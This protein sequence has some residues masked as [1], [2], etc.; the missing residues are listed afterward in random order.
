VADELLEGDG[1]SAL[2]ELVS[3]QQQQRTNNSG[4]GDGDSGTST[5]TTS[6]S[7]YNDDASEFGGGDIEDGASGDAGDAAGT[8]GGAS[9]PAR[10]FQLKLLQPADIRASVALRA[11]E[12]GFSG[13][14]TSSMVRALLAAGGWGAAASEYFYQVGGWCRYRVIA[15]CREVGRARRRERATSPTQHA[16][17]TFSPKNKK[18]DW[19]GPKG[20]LGAELLLA[21]GDPLQAVDVPWTPTTLVM[22]W[23]AEPQRLAPAPRAR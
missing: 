22:D 23:S 16:R 3:R 8:G 7:S 5:S 18:D 13:A 20:G 4:G 19:T 2:R 6:S 1:G 11:E 15:V 10:A 9:A 17:L 21:L 12:D 14:A